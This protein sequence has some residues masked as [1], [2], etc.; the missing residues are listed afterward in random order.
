[1]RVP[2]DALLADR[3]GLQRTPR[4]RGRLLFVW[5]VRCPTLLVR[6]RYVA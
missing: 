3:P 6:I 4:C 1:M 5:Q 2:L